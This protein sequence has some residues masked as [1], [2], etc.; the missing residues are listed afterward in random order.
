M[1]YKI[2]GVGLWVPPVLIKG[3]VSGWLVSSVLHANPLRVLSIEYSSWYGVVVWGDNLRMIQGGSWV[4]TLD[5]VR[6]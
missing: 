6:L 1:K 2:M 5:V 4:S 3:W